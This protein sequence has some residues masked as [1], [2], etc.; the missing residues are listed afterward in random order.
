MKRPSGAF[1][2]AYIDS[3]PTMDRR[4]KLS[5][6]VAALVAA[7]GA[8][9]AWILAPT[10]APA[11]KVPLAVVEHCKQAAELLY[12]V[13]WA[14][15]C[16]K[17]NDGDNDCTLPDDQAAKVNAI[18]GSEEARCTASEMQARASP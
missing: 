10:P 8:G 11:S 15:A 1:F 7:A 13:N 16:F 5:I 3:S 6:A 2:F 12:E 17:N 4:F 9:C 14:A 18:L